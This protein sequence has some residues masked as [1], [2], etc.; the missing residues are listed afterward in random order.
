[1][2]EQHNDTY[3]MSLALALAAEGLGRTAP[4]PSVGCVIVKNGEIIGQGRTQDGGRP[5]AEIVALE[6]AGSHAEG[7]TVYITLE[8][9]FHDDR[10]SCSSKLL[11]AKIARTVIACRDLNPLIH[12]RGIAALTQAGV[13]VVEGVLEQEAL[14]L[15]KGFFFSKIKSRPLVTLKIATSLDSKIATVSG[16]SQWITGEQARASVHQLRSKHDA[17]LTG[18]NTV[19]MDDPSLTTRIEGVTHNSR[20]IVL[21]THLRFP[22]TA[23]MLKTCDRGDIYIVCGEGAD[24]AKKSAL[25]TAGAKILE[26]PISPDGQLSIPHALKILADLGVTRLMVEA[27]QGVFSSFLAT[28]LWDELHLY[29]APLILGGDGRDAFAPL[30]IS[31]LSAALRPKL[32][33]RREIGDDLLE[34]YENPL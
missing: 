18:I 34:I 29:R 22:L 21:D 3:Y 6:Q 28:G 1:V 20:R 14:S 11:E 5:H 30:G 15:N 4:N 10:S 12:G 23:N 17:I 19:L 26:V 8:P 25:E 33:S 32:L 24:L 27:G 13:E 31:R 16:D 9:C 7:A 2:A